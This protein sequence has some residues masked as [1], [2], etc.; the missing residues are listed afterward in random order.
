M[1]AHSADPV[2]LLIIDSSLESDGT[3]AYTERDC[4]G[5]KL[6]EIVGTQLLPKLTAL[7]RGD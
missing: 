2:P 5:G 4:A 1:K 6:G 7:A 3:R